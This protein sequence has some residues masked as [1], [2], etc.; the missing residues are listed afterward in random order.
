MVS[1]ESVIAERRIVDSSTK[2][3]SLVSE[4]EVSA[5][6]SAQTALKVLSSM[7]RRTSP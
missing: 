5:K 3:E 4:R 7:A 1:K 6:V 2:E